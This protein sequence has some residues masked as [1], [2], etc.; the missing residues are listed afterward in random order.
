M[1]GK[2][3][4]GPVPKMAPA[5]RAPK[6]LRRRSTKRARQ[7]REY[8]RLRAPWIEGRACEMRLDGCTGRATEVHHRMGREGELLLD[9][10]FW[11]AGCHTCHHQVTNH[12]VDVYALGLSIRRN[13]VVLDG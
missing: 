1:T 10:R 7:E 2:R 4:A 12:E 9:V 13:G 11:M 5:T 3:W 6:R 8:L